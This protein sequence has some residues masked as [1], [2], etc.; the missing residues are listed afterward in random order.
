MKR[1]NDEHIELRSNK[2]RDIINTPPSWI[3]RYGTLIVAVLV[4][5]LFVAAILLHYPSGNSRSFVSY[6][7]Q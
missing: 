7:F 4:I 5:A 2:V 1:R 3:V 6:I